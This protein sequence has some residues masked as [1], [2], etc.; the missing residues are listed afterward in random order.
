[1]AGRYVTR[2]NMRTP[3]HGFLLYSKLVAEV[4]RSPDVL[5]KEGSGSIKSRQSINPP[6]HSGLQLRLWDSAMSSLS[7]NVGEER[8]SFAVSDREDVGGMG[9]RD[10]LDTDETEDCDV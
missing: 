7:L 4:D 10:L 1:M 2:Q 3:H 6:Q 8:S 5:V 9:V